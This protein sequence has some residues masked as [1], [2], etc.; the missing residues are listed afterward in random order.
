[1]WFVLWIC[2]KIKLNASIELI[3]LC[4]ANCGFICL[5]IMC[6]FSDSIVYVYKAGEDEG[7]GSCLEEVIPTKWSCRVGHWVGLMGAT[8]QGLHELLER[9]LSGWG[10]SFKKSP[11]IMCSSHWGHQME[12]ILMSILVCPWQLGKIIMV[13]SLQVVLSSCSSPIASF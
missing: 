5:K 11:V 1:M 10:L 13:N 6:F 7:M 8:A 9:K 4:V 2:L 12:Y 3:Y